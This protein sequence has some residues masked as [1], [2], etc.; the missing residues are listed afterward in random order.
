M[1]LSHRT[2]LKF[3]MMRV[4][5][6]SE[7]KSRTLLTGSLAYAFGNVLN[8]FFSLF[9]L[10]IFTNYLTPADY[11]LFGLLSI[12]SVIL[13]PVFSLGVTS[14]MAVPYF[15]TKSKRLRNSVVN[16]ALIISVFS[17]SAM[18]FLSVCFL[19][20]ISFFF[21]SFES[22]WRYILATSLTS[23]LIIVSAP[24]YL[25]LQ[26]NG[27]SQ[28]FVGVSICTAI[29]NFTSCI[30][31]IVFY[32]LG[33][34]GL[35]FGQLI[36][37]GFGLLMLLLLSGIRSRVHKPFMLKYSCNLLKLGIP[38]MPSFFL[39]FLLQNGVR[40][41]LDLK[42]NLEVVGVFTVGANIGS[43]VSV[44]TSAVI[45]A[46]TPWALEQSKDWERSRYSVSFRF[47][48][49]FVLGMIGVFLVF[50][51]AKPLLSVIVSPAFYSA[52]TVVGLYAASTF[53]ISIFSLMLTGLYI[54][55]KIYLV[56]IPQFFAAASSL[57]CFHYIFEP[58]AVVAA[59]SVLFGTLVLVFCQCCINHL[60][61]TISPLP[62]NYWR[63]VF[64]LVFSGFSFWLIYNLNFNNSFVY[65]FCSG[66]M[67]IFLGLAMKILF[68]PEI[69]DLHSNL[70]RFFK[71]GLLQ[72]RP[73]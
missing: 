34:G 69:E 59:L 7:T 19:E 12:L 61:K 57:I 18:V 29:V 70:R 48:Q 32:D 47:N 51:A 33:L 49:Y 37:Q 38:M 42:T 67:L 55:K 11:G 15:G 36:G 20:E 26:F 2:L 31:M 25:K 56:I 28:I 65:L 6:L 40:F 41:L 45:M 4:L 35:I 5:G 71:N 17:G 24:L 72:N 58:G 52:W 30:I 60:S 13:V 46:W 10:P 9:S 16:A 3:G 53:L 27:N 68:P 21:G 73:N 22:V 43:A 66:G 14:G 62:L 39:L 63:L 54:S 23:F 44:I 1:L 64:A 8:R 50:V